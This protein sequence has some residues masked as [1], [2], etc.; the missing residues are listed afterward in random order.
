RVQ[1]PPR[2][3]RLI[4]L[5]LTPQH[6]LVEVDRL[7]IVGEISLINVSG[8]HTRIEIRVRL[9]EKDPLVEGNGSAVLAKVLAGIDFSQVEAG[10]TQCIAARIVT[11][12]SAEKE[13][14]SLVIFR[15]IRDRP[16]VQPID[17]LA[18]YAIGLRDIGV[19]TKLG[20]GKVHVEDVGAFDD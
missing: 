16:T 17:R 2:V 7:A 9:V 15:P 6:L 5:D 18:K 20:T 3:L 10:L 8:P 19:R 4:G 14:G 13:L 11:N 12:E 1:A